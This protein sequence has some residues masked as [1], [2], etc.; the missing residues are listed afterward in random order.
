MS[1]AITISPSGRLFVERALEIV[2]TIEEEF[3]ER[4]SAAFDSSNA[5]GLLLLVS[6]GLTLSL[7]PSPGYWRDF[8]RG[9]LQRLCQTIGIDGAPAPLLQPEGGAL[10]DFARQAPPMRGGEFLTP[11]L[12]ERLWHEFA[13]LVVQETLPNG[14]AAWLKLKNPLWRTIGRVTFHL[15]ENKRD[16]DRP[17]AFLAYLCPSTLR[18]GR[19]AASAASARASKMNWKFAKAVTSP[20]E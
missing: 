12:L 16:S 8:A 1:L 15:A 4:L 6:D 7:P 17:F 10:C 5:E 3:A 11:H 20:G 13:A 14:L 9:Y 18:A 2:P 19:T